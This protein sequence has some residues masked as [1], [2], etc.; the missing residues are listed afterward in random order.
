MIQ[1][2]D[3]NKVQLVKKIF[4]IQGNFFESYVFFFENSDQDFTEIFQK[5]TLKDL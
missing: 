4:K 3:K 2:V 1:G 5:G